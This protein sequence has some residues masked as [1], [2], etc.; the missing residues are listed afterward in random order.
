MNH[1]SHIIYGWTPGSWQIYSHV[2][3]AADRFCK[4]ETSMMLLICAHHFYDLKMINRKIPITLKNTK[5]Y[6]QYH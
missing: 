4:D 1:L 2:C 6:I 5:P 3:H